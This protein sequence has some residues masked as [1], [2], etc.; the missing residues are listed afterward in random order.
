MF[1]ECR[2]TRGIERRHFYILIDV[3]FCVVVFFLC[4]R[5]RLTPDRCEFDVTTFVQSMET[6]E[7]LKQIVKLLL[8]DF[9]CCRNIAVE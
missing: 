8:P 2:Y 7:A 5:L 6:N 4:I 1:D 9:V 3:F